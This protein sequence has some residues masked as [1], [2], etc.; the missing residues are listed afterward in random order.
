MSE[1]S[2]AFKRLCNAALEHFA[3]FGYDGASLST[4]AAMIGIRKASLYSHIAGKDEL[5]TLLLA[6]AFATETAFAETCFEKHER[7]QLPG[8]G[9]LDQ[10]A[11][12]FEQSLHLQF[13]LRAAYFAPAVH[14]DKITHDFVTFFERLRSLYLHEFLQTFAGTTHAQDALTYSEA[15]IGIFDSLCVE[16]LYGPSER[17]KLRKSAM[18]KLMRDALGR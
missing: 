18:N 5:Y 14:R 9:Y 2:P 15:W 3:R 7:D 17:V 6:D 8:A 11:T 12:R 13:I 1:R 10:L 4:I 16:L